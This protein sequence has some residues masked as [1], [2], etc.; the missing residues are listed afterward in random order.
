MLRRPRC[1]ALLPA[2]FLITSSILIAQHR[3]F[4]PPA[5]SASHTAPSKGAIAD[6]IQAVLS[7]PALK[8]TDF[9]ISV[10]TLDGQPLYGLNESKLFTPASNAKLATT[11]AA[12][13][14]LPVETLTWTTNVVANGE[15]DSSGVLHGD[16][17]ILGSGDPT[18]SAH[19]Y[20]YQPPTPPAATPTP[21][22]P[23]AK[24]PTG[25]P[26]ATPTPQQLQ[27]E[28]RAMEALDL[29]A[30]QVVQAGVRSVE[31]SVVGDDSYYLNEPY[32]TAW[33]WDDLQ[34]GYG[35][36]ISALSF[37]D[38]SIELTIT[39]DPEKPGSML[40][41]WTP[42]VPYYTL[43][44]NMK[45]AP[46]GEKAYP[47]LERRPGALLVRTWGTAPVQGLHAP[48]AIEDPAEF[49]AAAFKDALLHRGVAV[50]GDPAAAHRLPEGTGDFIGERSERLTLAP[51]AIQT[52][53][54]P[55]NNRRLLAH[56]T[57]VPVA[58][59]ITVTNKVSQNL[60]AELILRMLGKAFA[61]DGSLAQGTRV[62][63]QF[64]VDT[65]IPDSDFFFYDGS[66]M[67]MDDRITP[68]AYTHLLAY[69]SHQ[70]WGQA[71]RGSF[72]VAGVDGSLYT[73]F[74]NSPLKGKLWAKTG[75]LNETNALSGYL[76]AAS[77]KTVAFSILVNGHR[78]GSRAEVPAIEKICEVIAAS[79]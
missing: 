26:E 53:E 48:L 50:K 66:G 59:D 22:N 41:E 36:P 1:L 20:P 21:A 78:P 30:Q 19:H 34:W 60:H 5:H 38:N 42:N 55:V 58:Q 57:S 27:A 2:L 29:L 8:Q 43:Q 18:I 76:Q 3:A 52:M 54:A 35:A 23:P 10:T 39:A 65:G 6:R 32:G 9:G 4:K 12:Y 40:E 71:W 64:L 70:H 14:L 31:G 47:G 63:R 44:N 67:S 51:L 75:T 77:G 56:H 25:K 13:A 24:S 16:I 37:A 72:P 46:P 11:A 68:R 79:E 15:I 17:L 73:R 33:A 45:M 62:V 61:K 28:P 69:A 7:D 49:T 74:R